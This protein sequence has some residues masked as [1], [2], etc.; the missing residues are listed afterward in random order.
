MADRV[1]KNVTNASRLFS[2]EPRQTVRAM[3]GDTEELLTIDRSY[4]VPASLRR[5]AQYKTTDRLL[6]W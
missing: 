6:L 5:A 2:L 4:G 3:E 1:C